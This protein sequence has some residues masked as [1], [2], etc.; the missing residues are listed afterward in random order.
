M[1]LIDA[2]ELKEHVWRDRLDSRELIAEMIDNAPTVKVISTNI[3]I[4]IFERLNSQEPCEDKYLKEIDHL[5]KYISKLETQIVEQEPKTYWIPVIERLP[6]KFQ[7]VLVTIVNY[8]GNK[9]VRVAEYYNRKETGVFQIKENHEEWEVGEKGLL[10]WMPLP[11][12]YKSE[13]E[14]DENDKDN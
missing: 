3:P 4:S 8:K 6:E 14:E 7:R 9:V 5:R 11:E 1:R 10:A 12:P 13:S 2:D